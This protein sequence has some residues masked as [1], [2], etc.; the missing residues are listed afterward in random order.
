MGEPNGR[1]NS[2][3]QTDDKTG[4]EIGRGRKSQQYGRRR[5]MGGKEPRERRK[6]K[7]EGL[8]TEKSYGR[9][10][11]FNKLKGDIED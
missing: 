5:S 9:R 1:E 3:H 2:G 4:G 6:E 7:G 8:S 11:T 10:R